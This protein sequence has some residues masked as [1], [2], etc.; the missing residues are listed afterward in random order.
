MTRLYAGTDL[1][2]SIS[3][4]CLRERASWAP[5][6]QILPAGLS[7]SFLLLDLFFSPSGCF[8]FAASLHPRVVENP[9]GE[10]IEAGLCHQCK[11]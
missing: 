11:F 8:R 9:T 1:N 10:E 6:T 4:A 7:S 3:E 2:I 5:E